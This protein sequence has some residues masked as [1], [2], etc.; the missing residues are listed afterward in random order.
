V[1]GTDYLN[2]NELC[3]ALKAMECFFKYLGKPQAPLSTNTTDEQINPQHKLSGLYFV[4]TELKLEKSNLVVI[5]DD[6]V[7]LDYIQKLNEDKFMFNPGEKI[8]KTQ[9]GHIKPLID[10]IFVSQRPTLFTQK[11]E[12]SF[13]YTLPEDPESQRQILLTTL[14]RK[15]EQ[16]FTS[17]QLHHCL[18]R[19]ISYYGA[20]ESEHMF[21]EKLEKVIAERLSGI[22]VVC[23]EDLTTY[24]C[25]RRLSQQQKLE[26]T[27][28]DKVCYLTNETTSTGNY[29]ILNSVMRLLNLVLNLLQ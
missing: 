12:E 3:K 22:K 14:E 2:S 16:L 29:S 10:K 13:D 26:Q 8:I 7:S 21:V 4:T 25:Y 28:E 23:V 9:T 5:V 24:L 18:A 27:R 17:K 15:Y 19:C 6:R 20:C 11:Y 1:C